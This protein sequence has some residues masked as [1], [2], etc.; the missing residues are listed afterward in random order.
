MVHKKR[1]NIPLAFKVFVK[2]N[3]LRQRWVMEAAWLVM[4][5]AGVT[6]AGLGLVILALIVGG[7]IR[8]KG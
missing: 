6:A 4:G 5:L 1:L 3:S 8:K 2:Y 7:V